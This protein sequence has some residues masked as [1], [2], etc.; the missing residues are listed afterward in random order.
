MTI[1]LA[2]LLAASV[3][4]AADPCGGLTV[5]DGAV[6]IGRALATGAAV[7]P[8]DLAC[9]DQIGKRLVD[10]GGVRSVTV[11]ARV[12]DAERAAGK[13]QMLAASAGARLTDAG[14]PSARITMVQPPLGPG[15]SRGVTVTFTEARAAR[16]IGMVVGVTGAVQTGDGAALSAGDR[17][18]PG[19]A[20]RTGPGASAVLGLADGSR[21]RVEAGTTL[22]LERLTLDA[23]RQ[24]RVEL[25]V[26]AGE[27]TALVER[28]GGSFQIATPA[29]T[30]GVRGTVFRFAQAE[31][32]PVRLETL[33]GTVNLA[34]GSAVDVTAGH[35]SRVAAGAAP[36]DPRALPA[37]PV[38]VS[39][40]EGPMGKA[41]TWD[42]V[43]G[44]PG[45][46]VEV[47]RDAEFTL[48]VRRADGERGTTCSPE[49]PDGRWFWRV[50][51]VDGDGFTGDWSRV[52][53][54][55]VP[56]AGG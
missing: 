32:A 2:A 51:A 18:A 21:V 24:R 10:R 29:G 55:E 38:V 42:R 43:R 46:R 27:V 14:I 15:Q 20:V 35:G 11:L 37:P 16:P 3:A 19:N 41:L 23:D 13:G 9:F 44:A 30:A 56:P 26:D 5:Q 7:T 34:G 6:T 48:D 4:G 54:F 1:V 47:A 33:E 22:V 17:L 36:E 39:P 28:P 49:L 8:D 45:W 31:A 40:R 52:Y 50:A 25:R 12:P 53:A